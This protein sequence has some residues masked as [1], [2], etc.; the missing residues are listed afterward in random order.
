MSGAVLTARS[1]VTGAATCRPAVFRRGVIGGLLGGALSGILA[2]DVLYLMRVI[3]AITILSG[4]LVW[5]VFTWLPKIVYRVLLF[6]GMFMWATI[7]G[8]VLALRGV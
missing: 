6:A 7:K 2:Y 8:F 5:N 3:L 1:H 4:L